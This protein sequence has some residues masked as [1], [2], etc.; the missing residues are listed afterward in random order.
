MR[1]CYLL[2]RN[3]HFFS[4]IFH[5]VRK[6]EKQILNSNVRRTA[7]VIL[8]RA[9]INK[10]MILNKIRS[11]TS[12]FP[13]NYV[14]VVHRVLILNRGS[15]PR[16]RTGRKWPKT[17]RK[18]FPTRMGNVTAWRHQRLRAHW[19]MSLVGG[20]GGVT[21]REACILRSPGIVASPISLLSMGGVCER[22][23]TAGKILFTGRQTCSLYLL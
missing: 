13:K 14:Y 1:L 10:Y 8:S 23:I 12:I 17:G 9:H 15:M 5:F 3:F 6:R 4:E 19:L 7:D 21:E 2:R 18:I 20:G 22:T 16:K 11:L